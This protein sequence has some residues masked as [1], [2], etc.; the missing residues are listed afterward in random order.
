MSH[1]PTI[2]L[3]ERDAAKP[4]ARAAELLAPY[5]E[6]GEWGREGTHWDWWVVGGRWTGSL[7]GYEPQHDPRNREV[8]DLCSGSGRRPFDP[9]PVGGGA[10]GDPSD[11]NRPRWDPD[12]EWGRQCGGCNGCHGQ[13]TRLKW[14]L[15]PHA[16]DIRPVS[17]ITTGFVP[18]AIVTPDGAWHEGWDQG[19][20]VAERGRSMS[21][22]VWVSEARGLLKSH[23]DHLAVLVDCHV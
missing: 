13:G 22:E 1:F 16:G 4:E 17:T 3:I 15:E 21:D 7:D 9:T 14:R 5:D 18:H 19:M 2:V 12:S 23:A 8:C 6:D 11:P 20:F 10:L